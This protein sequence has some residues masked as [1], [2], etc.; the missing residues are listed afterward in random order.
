MRKVA[1][2]ACYDVWS[3]APIADYNGM[4]IGIDLVNLT[5]L[6]PFETAFTTASKSYLKDFLKLRRS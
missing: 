4:N 1:G 3:A 2:R 5:S 6:T